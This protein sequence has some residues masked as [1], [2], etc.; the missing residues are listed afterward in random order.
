MN[1]FRYS[2]RQWETVYCRSPTP[3]PA[4][5][6]VDGYQP[7]DNILTSDKFELS[8]D[9]VVAKVDVKEGDLLMV[10]EQVH[11]VHFASKT[12]SVLKSMKEKY[13]VFQPVVDYMNDY[14]DEN[15][16]KYEVSVV[17]SRLLPQMY[18]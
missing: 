12:V 13:K 2:T 1:K 6:I 11:S 9:G 8:K 17:I 4:C 14:D 15:A 7:N 18:E 10:D 3:H 5:T 16:I